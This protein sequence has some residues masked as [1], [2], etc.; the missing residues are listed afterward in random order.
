[1]SSVLHHLRSSILTKTCMCC[2]NLFSTL[3][4]WRLETSN[5]FIYL[6]IS[7]TTFGNKTCLN[8]KRTQLRFALFKSCSWCHI[9]YLL[10]CNA[11]SQ[12]KKENVQGALHTF[13]GNLI[14]MGGGNH[15]SWICM[16]VETNKNHTHTPQTLPSAPR[17]G[18]TPKIW[19]VSCSL[20]KNLHSPGLMQVLPANR[21]QHSK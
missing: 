18:W 10:S 11:A 8:P 6:H 3:R 9:S 21:Y 12:Q 15:R 14:R 7:M 13:A 2:D 19:V 4:F 17:S 5:H 16:Y 20:E 1:M